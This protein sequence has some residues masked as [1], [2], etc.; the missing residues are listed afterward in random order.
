[1]HNFPYLLFLF[2]EASMDAT[3]ETVVTV[4]EVIPSFAA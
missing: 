2:S 4:T 3:S 1:M